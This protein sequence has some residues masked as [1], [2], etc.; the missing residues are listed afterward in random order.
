[1]I[2]SK[3][4]WQVID[5]TVKAATRCSPTFAT[6]R[7]SRCCKRALDKLLKAM[8][9]KAAEVKDVPLK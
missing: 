1:M 3:G 8:R 6:T 4:A 5:V 7:C 2:K 9:D